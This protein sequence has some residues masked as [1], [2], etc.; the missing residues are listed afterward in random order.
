MVHRGRWREIVAHRRHVEIAIE[1]ERTQLPGEH[2]AIGRGQPH[3]LRELVEIDRIARV[4]CEGDETGSGNKVAAI[5]IAA[6]RPFA[7]VITRDRGQRRGVEFVGH[8]QRA[9]EHLIIGNI[10][11][12]AIEGDRLAIIIVIELVVARPHRIGAE[13]GRAAIEAAILR[14]GKCAEPVARRQQQLAAHREIEIAAQR[15]VFIGETVVDPVAAALHLARKTQRERV[16][17]NRHANRAANCVGAVGSERAIGAH[18]GL[19][20]RLHCVDLDD[21]GRGVAA[22]QRALR[23]AQDLDPLDIE[24]REAFQRGVFKDDIVENDRNGLRCC[25]VEI[26]VAEPANIEARRD[27][28]VGAFHVQ[29]GDLPRQG[30]GVRAGCKNGGYAGRIQCAC[31]N[32]HV[33]EVL[34]AAVGSDDNGRELAIVV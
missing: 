12:A 8:L 25:K 26:G 30:G 10:A 6:A 17:D 1:I 24:Q 2:T 28:A 11:V 32:R 27:A 19:V 9:A 18:I 23:S 13:Q 7:F 5:D 15:V 29:T 3:F 16:F 20:A 33:L 31:R 4:R 14:S 22:E 21:A 34:F